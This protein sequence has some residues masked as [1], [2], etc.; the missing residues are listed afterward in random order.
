MSI[1]GVLGGLVGSI[2]TV[3]ATKVFDLIREGRQHRYALERSFF[4]KKLRAAEAA[5]AQWYLLA[6]SLGALAALYEKMSSSEKELS[7]EI[8]KGM[9]DQFSS[10]LRRVSEA[11]TE[12]PQAIPL[13]FDIEDPT[14]SDYELFRRFLDCLS[15]VQALDLSLA[16]TLKVYDVSKGTEYEQ[17]AWAEVKKID[18][19]YKHCFKELSDVVNEMQ[20]QTVKFLAKI[21]MEMKKYEP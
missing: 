16:V 3:I 12:I 21:R 6:S 15:N 11:T 20:K 7:F 2:L 9:H 14:A 19:Q 5:V 8:F 1:D 13:F 10:Q 4:E 18:Q 17:T